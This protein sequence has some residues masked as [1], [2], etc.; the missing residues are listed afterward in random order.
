MSYTCDGE[1]E[2]ILDHFKGVKRGSFLDIGANNGIKQSNTRRLAELGWEGVCIEPTTSV[3]EKL[4]YLYKDSKVRCI[5][6]AITP[7]LDGVISLG[8][9]NIEG[10]GNTV[11][12]ERLLKLK[13]KVQSKEDVVGV[14]VSTLERLVGVDFNFLSIDT[15]GYDLQL[16][17]KFNFK[18][19]THLSLICMEYHLSGDID[20]VMDI[21]WKL[22]YANSFRV[23]YITNQNVFLKKILV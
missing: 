11:N 23:V 2:F 7:S 21:I 13:G 4:S 18:Q 5:K 12:P 1:E 3:Y 16:I 20:F 10:L 15:E 9:V 8:V 14:C 17:Q 19:W 22:A 6:V